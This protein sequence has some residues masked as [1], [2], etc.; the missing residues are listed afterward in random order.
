MTE[1]EAI[2]LETAEGF[3][4]LYN[5]QLGTSFSIVKHS[6]APDFYCQDKKGS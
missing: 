1:K 2:E 6:D 5:S 3:I 4:K